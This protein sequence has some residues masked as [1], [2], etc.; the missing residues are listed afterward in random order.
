M[1]F[2]LKALGRLGKGIGNV[3]LGMANGLIGVEGV[4]G[5]E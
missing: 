1:S 4:L 5:G 3:V 2:Q